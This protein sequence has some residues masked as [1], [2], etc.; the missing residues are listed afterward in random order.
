MTNKHLNQSSNAVEIF[1][2]HVYYFIK[3][4]FPSNISINHHTV[5]LPYYK[6]DLT[7]GPSL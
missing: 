6:C 5:A 2:I 1:S 4:L 3:S 7:R